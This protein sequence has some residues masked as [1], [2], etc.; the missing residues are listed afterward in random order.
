ML[1]VLQLPRHGWLPKIRNVQV[2]THSRCN[3]NCWFCPWSESEHGTTHVGKMSDETWDRILLNLVPF[4]AGINGGKFCP[5]LMNEP[6]IDKSIFEK[7][8]GIYRYFP[9][10]CVEISTNGAALTDKTIDRLFELFQGKRHELWVSHHGIDAASLQHVMQI[11]YDQ[12]TENLINLLKKSNGRFNIKIRGAG[13]SRDGKHKVFSRNEYIAYW[14]RQFDQ[15]GINRQNV[16]L[17]AFTFHDRAGTLHR[18]ER[19]ANQLNMGTVRQI[20]SEHPFYCDRID[21][22]LHFGWDGSIRLCCMDYHHEIKLPNINETSLLDY[23]HGPD[24]FE[25]V[26]SIS[27][28]TGCGD[29]HICTRCTSPGG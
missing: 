10:T 7:I 12:A 28:E 14:D 1:K 17:D 4:A 26:S 9:D 13:E 5:Y 29:G 21:Q 25:L 2:M 27:G 18:D 8:S 23:F 20:D 15:H 16:S 3:A 22:W 24:Y 6:L 19:G 11:N